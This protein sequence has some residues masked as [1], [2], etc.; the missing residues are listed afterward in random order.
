M[1]RSPGELTGSAALPVEHVELP[2]LLASHPHH[3][4]DRAEPR[5]PDALLQV[6]EF[7]E[8]L[9]RRL[10]D[11]GVEPALAHEKNSLGAERELD[12]QAKVAEQV[13]DCRSCEA[14]LEGVEIA[15]RR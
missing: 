6:P 13:G 9:A 7:G 12:V 4:S 14:V 11:R 3:R 2:E 10:V 15:A 5:A 8:G 1:P